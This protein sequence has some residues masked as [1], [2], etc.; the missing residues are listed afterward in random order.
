MNG[1]HTLKVIAK[2]A[3]GNVASETVLFSLYYSTDLTIESQPTQ[4]SDPATINA[5]LLSDGL[6]VSGELITIMLNGT[7]VGG[8]ITDGNGTVMIDRIS[9][10]P[11]G[12]YPIEAKYLQNNATYYKGS[13]ASDNVTIIG[14]NASITYM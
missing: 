9:D 4:H 1:P 14:E 6:P 12:V 11:S 5:T 10:L 7:N 13:N 3:A 8:G 2:D